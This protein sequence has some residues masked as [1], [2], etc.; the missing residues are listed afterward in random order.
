MMQ[1][2]SAVI[3]ALVL[4]VAAGGGIACSSTQPR[5]TAPT[6][7]STAPSTS[8]TPTAAARQTVLP[9]AELDSPNRVA[10]DAAGTVYV[11]DACPTV[12]V[13]RVRPDRVLKLAAGSNTQT[14]L[15]FPDLTNPR[16]V[17][18]DA[19]GSV[20][21][22]DGNR[23]V[24]LAAGS[25]TQTVL[26]LTD[27]NRPIDV[28]V[29]NAGN[30]YVLDGTNRAVKLAAGSNVQTV[31]PFTGL[32]GPQSVAVDTAGNVYLAD[33]GHLRVLKLAAVPG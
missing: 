32:D 33:W 22:V 24:K 21:V 15:P 29:D 3:A 14:A 30:V 12:E 6:T 5:A 18:V 10:V 9:F 26:P 28:A 25:G 13:C 31:L 2:R 27:L 1:L 20:Y 8:S 16:G 7:A 23:V 19:A 4:A 11:A 17:A